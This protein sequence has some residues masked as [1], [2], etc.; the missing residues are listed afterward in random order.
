MGTVV[1]SNCNSGLISIA[2]KVENVFFCNS[3]LLPSLLT[4]EN[5]ENIVC[6]QSCCAIVK[7]CLRYTTPNSLRSLSISVSHWPFFYLLHEDCSTSGQE[8]LSFEIHNQSYLFLKLSPL[9][10]SI[11]LP[12]YKCLGV[13]LD[14]SL[15]Q[16]VMS[17]FENGI[18][19]KSYQSHNG[20]SA[21]LY[22]GCVKDSVIHY[23]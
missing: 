19:L 5:S 17:N 22:V 10:Q 18:I 21:I 16:H 12:Q 6:K 13:D 3:C 11:E 23:N 7:L 8:I 9:S 15:I 4:T 1:H 20:V 2:L 14:A